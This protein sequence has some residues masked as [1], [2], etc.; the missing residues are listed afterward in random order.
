MV[1]TVQIQILNSWVVLL[2]L[3]FSVIISLARRIGNYNSLINSHY[4]KRF[5]GSKMFSSLLRN[6]YPQLNF[7]NKRPHP[8]EFS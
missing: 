1:K 6:V 7:V 8:L 3:K 4:L 5:K 2:C